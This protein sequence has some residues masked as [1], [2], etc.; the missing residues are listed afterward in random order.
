MEQHVVDFG[1]VASSLE[2]PTTTTEGDL[3]AHERKKA[4][5]LF[6]RWEPGN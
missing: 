2:S 4:F 3:L 1:S 6:Y 5:Q